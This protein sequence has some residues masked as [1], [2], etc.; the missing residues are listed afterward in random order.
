VTW[1]GAPPSVIADAFRRMAPPSF[2]GQPERAS[3]AFSSA[4]HQGTLIV[5]TPSAAPTAPP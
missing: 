1:A 2:R 4:S 3:F 5:G